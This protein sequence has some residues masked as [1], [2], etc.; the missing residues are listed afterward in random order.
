MPRYHIAL[1]LALLPAALQGQQEGSCPSGVVVADHGY[2]WLACPDCISAR[3]EGGTWH[4]VYLAP[5][6]LHRIRPDGPAAGRLR[7]N[8]LLLAVDRL[9]IVSVAG[10]RRLETWT[11]GKTTTLTVLRAGDTLDVTLRPVPI[12]RAP[13]VRQAEIGTTAPSI[14]GTAWFGFGLSCG[15]CVA[16]TGSTGTPYWRFPPSVVIVAVE[17]CGPADR[18][19]LRVGDTLSA[20][21]GAPLHTADGGARLRRATPERAVAFTIQRGGLTRIVRVLPTRQR[22]TVSSARPVC[23][24]TT[25]GGADVEVTGPEA[26]VTIDPRTGAVTIR[27]PGVHVLVR[28]APGGP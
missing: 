10:Q 23:R 21:D 5:P 14:A 19:G 27:G 12:C 7:E 16:S 6:S 8:D 1:L 17:P 4:S 2:T 20:I 15:T 11:P 24:R 3:W 26:E 9:S 22:A 18:A 13:A 25:V 28:P